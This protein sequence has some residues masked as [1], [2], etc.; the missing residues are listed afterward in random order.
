MIV[1][2]KS[3]LNMPR[4]FTS[5]R[6]LYPFYVL[7]DS[8]MVV[9]FCE[10]V[11]LFLCFCVSFIGTLLMTPERRR[12]IWAIYGETHSRAQSN[13]VTKS[14]YGWKQHI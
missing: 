2:E 4:H 12:A 10:D 9:S 7:L 13:L 1:A 8:V 6:P 3:V 5:V 14:Y 11:I